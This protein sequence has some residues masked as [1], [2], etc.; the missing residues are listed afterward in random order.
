MKTTRS[1][2]RSKTNILNA[3]IIFKR[4]FSTTSRYNSPKDP[5]DDLSSGNGIKRKFEEDEDSAIQPSKRLKEDSNNP[6]PSGSNNSNP[7]GSN[8]SP[9]EGPSNQNS[10]QFD[11]NNR[12]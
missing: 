4:G 2:P 9:G 8:N 1:K 6:S 5:T 11:D 10:T 7:S 3:A 12:Q